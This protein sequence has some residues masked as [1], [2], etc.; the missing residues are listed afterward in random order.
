MWRNCA[1]ASPVMELPRARGGILA[2]T[3]GLIHE[4]QQW[5]L[6]ESKMFKY[7]ITK[8]AWGLMSATMVQEVAAAAVDDNPDPPKDLKVARL[9]S[10]A[11][12]RDMFCVS[13]IQNLSC[14]VIFVIDR[15]AVVRSLLP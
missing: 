11:E 9:G 2:R 8:F 4:G 14:L 15:M 13:V 12:F 3:R 10:L 5:H 6:R 7:L 1:R